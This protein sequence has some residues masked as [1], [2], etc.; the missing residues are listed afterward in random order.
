MDQPG[1][2]P[3]LAGE[4]LLFLEPYPAGADLPPAAR[5]AVFVNYNCGQ[6]KEWT[7]VSPAERRELET[8][9]GRR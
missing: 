9:A 8:L 1:G 7:Q 3:D 4:Y 6:S 2:L 5:G